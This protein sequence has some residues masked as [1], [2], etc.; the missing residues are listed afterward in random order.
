VEEDTWKF[1]F[2]ESSLDAILAEHVWEHL[3][4]NEA[5]IA[6]KNC[7]KYLK[8]GGYVRVAVPDGYHPS[9]L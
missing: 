6:A 8:H 5:S 3:S 7:F 9:P 4:L 2:Q 1:F